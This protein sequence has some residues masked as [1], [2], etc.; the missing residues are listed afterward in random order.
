M[1]FASTVIFNDLSAPTVTVNGPK[2]SS[3]LSEATTVHGE[4]EDHTVF[5]YR[6]TNTEV[7]TW[8]MTLVE[9]TNAMKLALHDF[10]YTQVRGSNDLFTYTHTDVVAY[11]GCRFLQDKLTWRRASKA[12]WN[13]EVKIRVPSE[14][15]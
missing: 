8:T 5:A 13:V 10:F 2:S 14:V 4:T 15:L 7:D 11:P 12:L 3:V 6:P 1:A 9:L